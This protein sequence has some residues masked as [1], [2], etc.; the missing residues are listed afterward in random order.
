VSLLLDALKRAERQSEAPS[1]APL[2]EVA[3]AAAEKGAAQAAPSRLRGKL[4]PGRKEP[5]HARVAAALAATAIAILGAVASVWHASKAPTPLA[6]LPAPAAAAPAPSRDSL[7]PPAAPLPTRPRANKPELPPPAGS[8]PARAAAVAATPAPPSAARWEREQLAAALL[9]EAQAAPVPAVRIDATPQARTVPPEV[10]RGYEALRAGDHAAARRSYQAA[11]AADIA[12][13]DANL[14]LATAEAQAGN[15]PAAALLYRKALELDPHNATALAGLA[16]LAEA[17]RPGTAETQLREDITRNPQ[18][19]ALRFALGNVHAAHRRWSEAQGEYFE[20]HRLDP[21]DPDIS[22]NLAVS[23]DSLGRSAL[24]AG[25][26]RRALDAAQRR[27][28]RFEAAAVTRRL[29]EM[30]S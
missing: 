13:L 15:V 16:L 1:G 7:P 11:L 2:V 24:A 27:P 20:A 17:S 6:G 22:F 12:N 28:A 10:S 8:R 25:F 9:Q 26:Y 3:E 21:S 29:A 18:S 4:E 30:G 14:G 19:A 23:L 5:R